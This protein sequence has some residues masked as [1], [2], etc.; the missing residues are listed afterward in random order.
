M[1][2]CNKTN[3]VLRNKDVKDCANDDD[4]VS[5]IHA[6]SLSLV[7][8]F[9]FCGKY[10]F[11]FLKDSVL[12]YMKASETY[13]RL[14]DFEKR[15]GVLKHDNAA[16]FFFFPNQ[17]FNPDSWQHICLSVSKVSLKLV[18]NGDVIYDAYPN[19]IMTSYYE[20]KLYLGGENKAKKLLIQDL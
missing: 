10:S 7:D 11:K 15:Y 13:I 5:S 4:T 14:M 17:T 3:L 18:I 6:K 20:T 19:S 12:M 1:F 2:N 9:T 16:N 8:E